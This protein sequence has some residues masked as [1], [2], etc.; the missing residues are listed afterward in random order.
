M[1]HWCLALISRR[2]RDFDYFQQAKNQPEQVSAARWR[3]QA[4]LMSSVNR[5][6]ISFP[7]TLFGHLSRCIRFLGCN[8]IDRE[9]VWATWWRRWANLISP[10]NTMT[11][12]FCWYSVQ[13][14]SY[15]PSGMNNSEVI[16]VSRLVRNG[17]HANWAARGR[18]R[19]TVTL[20]IDS[21]ISIC[22][23]DLLKFLVY[24]FPFVSWDLT[25]E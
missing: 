7:F 19:T 25:A 12:I 10:F 9:T 22:V 17:G 13:F 1:F 23:A 2:L 21:A 15:L 5:F 11:K 18:S 14:N 20:S 4:H 24:L 8:K 16:S 6:P 3:I